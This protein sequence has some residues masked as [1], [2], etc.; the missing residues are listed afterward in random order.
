[1]KVARFVLKVVAA[2]LATAAVV[3]CV[4]AF[5]DKL[6]EA[7]GCAKDKLCTGRCHGEYVDYADW[8]AE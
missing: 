3:C 8:D 5:W 6:A 7:V 4:V 2:A 1:M